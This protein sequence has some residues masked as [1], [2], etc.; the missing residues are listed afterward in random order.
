VGKTGGLVWVGIVHTTYYFIKCIHTSLDGITDRT[1][2]LATRRSD[3][4]L[5]VA[6]GFGI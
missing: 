4:E 3:G 1:S 2:T 5:G 6:Y